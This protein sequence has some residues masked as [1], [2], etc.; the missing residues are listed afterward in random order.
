MK[1]GPDIAICVWAI[2]LTAFNMGSIM[3]P[4][5]QLN[6]GINGLPV[7]WKTIA[8]VGFPVVVSVILLLSTLG[9]IPDRNMQRF[10]KVVSAHQ[11]LFYTT[12]E[13]NDLL[14]QNQNIM[15]HN[16]QINYA[17]CLNIASNADERERCHK[18]DRGQS[19]Q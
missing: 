3:A 13:N 16:G 15:L 8:I 5:H 19:I 11:S 9:I 17:L 1:F 2:F 14:K 12:S 4:M 7:L 6:E 18:A 10:E